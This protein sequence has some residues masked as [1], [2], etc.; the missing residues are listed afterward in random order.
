M[1]SHSDAIATAFFSQY[2]LFI[3]CWR[4]PTPPP[5]HLP[6]LRSHD[7]LFAHHHPR[8]TC[9]QLTSDL[10]QEILAAP[11]RHRKQRLN[12]WCGMCLMPTCKR[13]SITPSSTVSKS[14]GIQGVSGTPLHLQLPSR[15]DDTSGDIH[16][17]PRI[18]PSNSTEAPIYTEARPT[19]IDVTVDKILDLVKSEIKWRDDHEDSRS[20]HRS[21]EYDGADGTDTGEND[22]DAEQPQPGSSAFHTSISGVVRTLGQSSRSESPRC[23]SKRRRK[24]P[25]P[26]S[27]LSRLEQ[28]LHDIL[29]CVVC[30][31]MLYDP[32]LHLASIPFA[33]DVSLGR[34]ITPLGA[35]YVDKT[36]PIWRS[37]KMSTVSSWQS[38]RLFSEKRM[39]NENECSDAKRGMHGSR[40]LHSSATP[41]LYPVCRQSCMFL[42]R[43]TGL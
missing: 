2:T 20:L 37:F 42:N 17:N 23:P 28:D 34:S 39:P 21:Y 12:L 3:R 4:T 19:L 14:D 41:L 18:L 32:S 30:A 11:Q 35:P 24:V 38:S 33:T 6:P 22:D 13:F 26:V 36:Y 9:A 40:R 15:R 25:N 8:P 1:V 16:L 29:E 7:V 5:P 31:V 27:H 43:G 10:S